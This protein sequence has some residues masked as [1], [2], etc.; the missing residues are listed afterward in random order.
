MGHFVLLTLCRCDDSGSN[1][2][3]F[4]VGGIDAFSHLQNISE[5]SD[6][7]GTIR[8]VVIGSVLVDLTAPLREENT[9]SGALF[10]TGPKCGAEEMTCSEPHHSGC[11]DYDFES[12]CICSGGFSS[13][14]CAKRESKYEL[15]FGPQWYNLCNI[16]A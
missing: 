11:L 5:Y 12:H 3:T 16:M 14:T 6:F 4:Y 1:I 10:A 7:V 15:L 9:I 8:N 2:Q 13:D